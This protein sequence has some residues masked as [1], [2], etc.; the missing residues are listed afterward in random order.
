MVRYVNTIRNLS[1]AFTKGLD[2]VKFQRLTKILMNAYT[3][4]LNSVLISGHR[5]EPRKLEYWDIS[6]EEDGT[7]S[8]TMMMIVAWTR[9]A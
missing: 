3:A 5:V 1:D 6:S 7:S 4:D 2:R 9:A 8:E